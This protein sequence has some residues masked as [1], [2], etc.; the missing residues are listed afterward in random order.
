MTKA[1]TP[2]MLPLAITIL[3][4]AQ[5]A[6]AQMGVSINNV[7]LT[8]PVDPSFMGLS[9][10]PL[11]LATVY[12]SQPEFIQLISNLASYRTGPF[13]IRWGGNSQDT[14]TE[15][16]GPDTWETLA[17]LHYKTGCVYI[18]GLNLLIEVGN[19]PDRFDTLHPDASPPFDADYVTKGSWYDDQMKFM[20]ALAP[21]L[22]KK[23]GTTKI[24]SGPGIADISNWRTEYINRWFREFPQYVKGVSCHWYA[25]NRLWSNANMDTIL[26]ETMMR[27]TYNNGGRWANLAD[28]FN[29]TF[30][31]AETNSIAL[32]G[33][34]GV[35]D[36]LGAAIFVVDYAMNLI[37]AG[38]HGMNLHMGACS[39]YSAI[40]LPIICANE[41][42]SQTCEPPTV[43]GARAPYYGMWLVQQALA[44]TPD[45]FTDVKISNVNYGNVKAYAFKDTDSG[46]VRVVIPKKSGGMSAPLSITLKGAFGHASLVI[47]DSSGGKLT[48]K[49]NASG[50]IQGTFS[51]LLISANTIIDTAMAATSSPMPCHH[52]T[53]RIPLLSHHP[54]QHIHLIPMQINASGNIQGTFSPLIISAS[55]VTNAGVTTT[56]YQF[57]IPAASAALLIVP[58]P[59]QPIILVQTFVNAFNLVSEKSVRTIQCPAF[60]AAIRNRLTAVGI[61]G[62]LAY[63][64]SAADPENGCSV[65]SPVPSNNPNRVYYKAVLHLPANWPAFMDLWTAGD[66]FAGFGTNSF[67]VESALVC[68]SILSVGDYNQRDS[69]K[70]DKGQLDALNAPGPCQVRSE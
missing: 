24:F 49:I 17:N 16:L 28:N 27:V 60:K 15:V 51:P 1:S 38:V 69:G 52:R 45:R 4:A 62:V 12:A 13:I 64:D 54:T 40:A 53:I 7:G 63:P 67:V 33:L 26:S 48:D 32:G 34:A 59:G 39:P 47:L 58:R 35:S 56:N 46:E 44:G 61:D 20:T 6:F 3:L 5:S 70:W 25:T 19:E 21:T 8:D 2:P 11:D 66:D 31:F 30:R 65:I 29:S 10:E 23:L 43:S 41:G 9:M 42:C 37:K 36:T 50:N 22:M 57:T 14:L 68:N 18:M 55:T